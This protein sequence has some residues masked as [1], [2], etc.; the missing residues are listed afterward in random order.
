M[1]SSRFWENWDQTPLAAT[2]WTHRPAATMV[3]SMGDRAGVPWN[4]S[5]YTKPWFET[6]LDEAESIVEPDERRV[7]VER[8]QKVMQGDAFC[9]LPARQPVNAIASNTVH[10]HPAIPTTQHQFD[11]DLAW[12]RGRN[13]RG[14]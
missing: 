14:R 10:G 3:L 12:L 7:V 5:D 2:S 8:V 4:A 13:F 1:P 11:K 9:F 6:A